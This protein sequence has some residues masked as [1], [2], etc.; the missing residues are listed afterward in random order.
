MAQLRNPYS[1]F[2]VDPSFV[3]GMASVMDLGGVLVDFN[4]APTPDEA[5]FLALQY[6]WFKVGQDLYY[7]LNTFKQAELRNAQQMELAGI[8]A[9]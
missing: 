7:A 4:A 8:A 6:D 9:G 1:I 3:A 2:F 5:D